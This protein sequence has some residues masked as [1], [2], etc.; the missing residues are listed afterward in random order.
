MI[1]MKKVKETDIIMLYGY[2]IKAMPKNTVI[3]VPKALK[4]DFEKAGFEVVTKEKPKNK[5]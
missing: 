1:E 3:K 4:K 2:N 5:E